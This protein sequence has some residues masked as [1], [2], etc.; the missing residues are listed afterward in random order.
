MIS[1]SS[2]LIIG[3]KLKAKKDKIIAS[4]NQEKAIFG[5]YCIV[6]ASNPS[7]L[8]DILD[9]NELHFAP[10]NKS[11]IKIVGIAKGKD[12]A[13]SLVQSMVME[14]YNTTGNFDVREYFT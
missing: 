1:W 11:D 14:V 5:I 6:F 8:F 3:E 12:E 13:L 9:A 10:Y 4:I 7:N 2:R